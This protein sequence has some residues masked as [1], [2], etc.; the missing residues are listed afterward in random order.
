MFELCNVHKRSQ[1]NDASGN[2]LISEN[3]ILISYMIDVY[4]L[5]ISLSM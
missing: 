4:L 5:L 3:E 2:V 1:E